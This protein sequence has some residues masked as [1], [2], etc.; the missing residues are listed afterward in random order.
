MHNGIVGTCIGTDGRDETVE[1]RGVMVEK[2]SAMLEAG[3]TLKERGA[4]TRGGI[5]EEREGEDLWAAAAIANE[6]LMEGRAGE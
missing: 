1:G 5:G 2:R 4:T 3:C 6:S